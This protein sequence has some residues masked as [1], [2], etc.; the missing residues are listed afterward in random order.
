MLD[1]EHYTVNSPSGC[2]EWTKARSGAGY[3]QLWDGERVVY[4]HRLVYE[5][6]CGP[7]PEGMEVCHR[8][9]NPPCRRLDH[10]FLGTH[11][12]NFEDAAAKGRVGGPP[13]ERC[14]AAKLT[15]AQVRAIR[16]DP[17]TNRVVCVD[18]GISSRNVSSIRLRQT[19][20]HV[21]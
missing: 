12:Q 6:A 18:Y 1:L 3:G 17:R 14:G 20:R 11:K 8:C 4:V 15:D 21:S 2:W 10:L 19:W 16:A 7:I 5:Q 9:D 13:G